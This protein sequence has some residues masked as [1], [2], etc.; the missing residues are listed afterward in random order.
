MPALDP[1]QTAERIAAIFRAPLAG[2]LFAAEVLYRSPEFEP[3]VIMPAALASVVS[4]STF[5]AIFGWEPLFTIPELSFSDPVELLAYL[6]LSR[7]GGS[8]E[9][10]AI[11]TLVFAFHGKFDYLYYNAGSM[12]D[13][14]CCLFYF[15]ALLITCE[16][17]GRIGCWASGSRSGFSRASSVLS[18][19]RKWPRCCR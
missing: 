10:G 16:P 9:I 1:R 12:Y 5:G 3:E 13:A 15:S 4:Y 2:S 19:P 6:V 11:A 14:F 8:R 7:L 18:I 17:A